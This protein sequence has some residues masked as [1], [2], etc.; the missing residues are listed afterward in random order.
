VIGRALKHPLPGREV[1]QM[2]YDDT[3]QGRS[4]WFR[5]QF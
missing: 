1:E 3:E 2:L 5:D 4:N